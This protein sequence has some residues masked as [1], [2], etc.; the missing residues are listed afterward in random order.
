MQYFTDCILF[1]IFQKRFQC[2]HSIII[3][4]S[5]GGIGAILI[6][7]SDIFIQ[8]KKIPNPIKTKNIYILW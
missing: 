2:F 3:K 7:F 1:A 6:K 4:I 8:L 5:E